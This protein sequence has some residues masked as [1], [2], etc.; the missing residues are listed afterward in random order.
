[1][2]CTDKKPWELKR[3]ASFD[4]TLRIPSEF[5]DGHFSGWTLQSQVRT[6]QGG[7]IAAL[8][9]D[10]VDP[11]TA[12]FVRLQC[13]DTRAWPLG[14]AAFDVLFVSPTGYRWPSSTATFA[15]VR[16]PTDA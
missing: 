15:V 6:P 8:S 5:A 1:M 4:L 7:L 9:A 3:G 12:R 14:E 13:L 10:W 11:V 16:G 2:A